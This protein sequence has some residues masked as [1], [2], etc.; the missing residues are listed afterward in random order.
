MDEDYL[1]TRIRASLE[2]AAR[3]AGSAARLIHLELAGRYSLMAASSTRSAVSTLPEPVGTGAT[4][5]YRDVPAATRRSFQP[6]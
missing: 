4:S 6:V 5:F 2:M 3:A 1:T